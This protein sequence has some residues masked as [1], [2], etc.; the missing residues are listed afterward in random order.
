M[1]LIVS[2]LTVQVNLE[3][4]VKEE[5]AIFRVFEYIN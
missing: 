1:N 4:L 3:D 5:E 2:E